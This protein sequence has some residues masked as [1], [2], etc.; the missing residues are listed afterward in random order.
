MPDARQLA[1]DHLHTGE[2]LAVTYAI[3][4]QYV[5]T[6]LNSLD[7]FLR[8]HYSGEIGRMDPLLFDLLHRVKLVLGC[9]QPFQVIS[10]YR[11]PATN[12][13]LRT[14]RDGGVAKR[15]LHMEGKAIDVRIA[16]LPLAEL[17]DAALSLR[18]GGVGFYPQEQFVHLDTGRMRSW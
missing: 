14:T 13:S 5:P 11:C 4:E 17:R 6:A 12:T 8:D 16:G 3:G 15:S 18:A 9:E 2:S 1:F 10:G 7:H